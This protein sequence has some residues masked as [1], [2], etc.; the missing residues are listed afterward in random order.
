MTSAARRPAYADT[1]MTGLSGD[2][3]V[4]DSAEMGGYDVESMVATVEQMVRRG[5]LRW[6]PGENRL[7]F[8]PRLVKR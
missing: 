4:A 3:S 7:V 5:V 2:F 8:A 6:V 1:L